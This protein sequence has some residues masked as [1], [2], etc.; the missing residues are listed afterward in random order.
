MSLNWHQIL[1]SDRDRPQYLL[2]RVWLVWDRPAYQTFGMIDAALFIV[3][4]LF[5]PVCHATIVK[6]YLTLPD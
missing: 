4:I 5:K 6:Y 2:T 1:V 3:G